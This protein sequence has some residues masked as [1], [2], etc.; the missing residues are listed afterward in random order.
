MKTEFDLSQYWF[1]EQRIVL[2]RIVYLLNFADTLWIDFIVGK[3][4]DG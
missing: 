4:D 2:P 1:Y 3:A